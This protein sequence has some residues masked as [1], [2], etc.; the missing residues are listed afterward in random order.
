MMPGV[1]RGSRW[2]SCRK[3]PGL[4]WAGY[5]CAHL[6]CRSQA[7]GLTVSYC[8]TT[9]VAR[10]RRAQGAVETLIR[11]RGGLGLSNASGVAH[12]GPRTGVRG[13][14]GAGS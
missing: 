7:L 11:R 10:G 6:H 2:S 8:T 4:C 12:V 1:Q 14:G 3:T 9:G 5:R 13:F